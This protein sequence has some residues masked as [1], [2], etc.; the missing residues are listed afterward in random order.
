MSTIG[1]FRITRRAQCVLK[2][3]SSGFVNARVM[4][5]LNRQIT[6]LIP[7]ELEHVIEHIGYD[8]GQIAQMKGEGAV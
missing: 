2:S 4:V 5:P 8:E 7:H 3:Y 6:E 1:P